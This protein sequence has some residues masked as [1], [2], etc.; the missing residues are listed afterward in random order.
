MANVNIC[1]YK[2]NIVFDIHLFF[3]AYLKKSSVLNSI[4]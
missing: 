1:M 2:L 4:E 3:S